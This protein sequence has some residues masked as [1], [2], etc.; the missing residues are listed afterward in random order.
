[1]SWTDIFKD[2]NQIL[3]STPHSIDVFFA[4]EDLEHA[5]H[6]Y[7]VI[8]LFDRAA[9]SFKIDK[10]NNNHDEVLKELKMIFE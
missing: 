3:E 10:Y 2:K 7:D 1:M 4:I 6:S 9:D 8:K 5:N